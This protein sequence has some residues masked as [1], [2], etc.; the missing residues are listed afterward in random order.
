MGDYLEINGGGLLFEINGVHA[1]Y[2]TVS[3]NVAAHPL[4]TP[5]T[6]EPTTGA[7]AT[8]PN[9]RIIRAAQPLANEPP[10]DLPVGV[11]IDVATTW[12]NGS[13]PPPTISNPVAFT[14]SDK[15]THFD[16]LFAP[17]GG[18]SGVGSTGPVYLLLRQP[19]LQQQGVAL[20][21]T[22]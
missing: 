3:D 20:P 22:T 17:S 21:A 1:K 14:D 5:T 12:N 15:K 4:P 6:D 16:I 13:Q 9:Y 2:L 8:A 11:I 18:L 7:A 19:D 10:I